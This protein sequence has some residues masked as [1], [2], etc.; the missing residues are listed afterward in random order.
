MI[1]VIDL[2]NQQEFNTKQ[3]LKEIKWT[4]DRISKHLMRPA[5]QVSLSKLSVLKAVKLV[6]WAPTVTVHHVAIFCLYLPLVTMFEIT[7]SRPPSEFCTSSESLTSYFLTFPEYVLFNMYPIPFSVKNRLGWGVIS[8]VGCIKCPLKIYF[9]AVLFTFLKATLS[10]I[11][12]HFMMQYQIYTPDGGS[13]VFSFYK[14]DTK[15]EKML[16]VGHDLD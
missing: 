2:R 13:V 9:Q 7:A 12:I 3:W 5:P 4:R 14:C 10:A 6:D 16:K 8:G 15:L 1:A 11:E